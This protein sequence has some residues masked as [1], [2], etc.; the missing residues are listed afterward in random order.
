MKEFFKNVS[1]KASWFLGTL[2]AVLLII[3]AIFVSTNYRQTISVIHK[4]MDAGG[5]VALILIVAACVLW[6]LGAI[7]KAVFG[8]SSTPPRGGGPATP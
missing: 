7:L 8:S 5:Q 6:A 4:L 1:E 2:I 3:L